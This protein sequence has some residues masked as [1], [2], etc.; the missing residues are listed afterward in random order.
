MLTDFVFVLLRWQLARFRGSTP[1]TKADSK[2]GS[3][4][5]VPKIF[6]AKMPIKTGIKIFQMREER[7][8]FTHCA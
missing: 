8:I 5:T 1:V 6:F 2:I 7:E 4:P 3:A